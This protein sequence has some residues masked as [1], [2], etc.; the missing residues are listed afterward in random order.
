MLLL[1]QVEQSQNNQNFDNINIF[2]Y[3]YTEIL[4]NIDCELFV[5]RI[6]DLAVQ[7]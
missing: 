2:L 6:Y 4:F 1:S 3:Y 5:N 7:S